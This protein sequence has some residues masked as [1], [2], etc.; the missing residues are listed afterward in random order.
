MRDPNGRGE[1]K[2]E[3]ELRRRLLLEAPPHLVDAIASLYDHAIDR[4]F[5][6]SERV[7]SAAEGKRLLTGD[8]NTEEMADRV[9]R[10]VVV[11]SPVLRTLFRGARITKV[12]WVL[13][14]STTFSIATTLRAGVQEV[15]VIGSLLAHRMEQE[16]GLPADQRLVRR[17]AL[18]LYL[19]PRRTPSFDDRPLPLRRLGQRWLFKGAFGRDTRK[20]ASKALDAAERLDLRRYLAA[21]LGPRPGGNT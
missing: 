10:V 16:T 12:P 3:K 14:A 21:R 11:A 18:E 6:T 7:T 8:D 2:D 19:W 13:V 4:V 9:Q 17:L 5:S 20:A 15:Q 1:E